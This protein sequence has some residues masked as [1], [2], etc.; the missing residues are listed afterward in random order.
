[1]VYVL[2]QKDNMANGVTNKDLYE[3]I[4]DIEEKMDKY[5]VRKEEFSPIKNIVNLMLT[6]IVLAVIGAIMAVVLN[7]PS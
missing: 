5:Y 2:R 1:M 4:K 7:N 3:A 6:T